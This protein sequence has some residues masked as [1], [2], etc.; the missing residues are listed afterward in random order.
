MSSWPS[1]INMVGERISENSRG[2]QILKLGVFN[3]TVITV[4]NS[5]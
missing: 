4:Y 5:C 2:A 1:T 3:K